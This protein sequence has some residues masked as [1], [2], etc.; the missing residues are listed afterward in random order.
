M[1]WMDMCIN[2][3]TASYVPSSE[4]PLQYSVALKIV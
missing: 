1:K 4:K 3:Y 2:G